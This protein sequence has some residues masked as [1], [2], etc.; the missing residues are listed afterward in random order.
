M[1][2]CVDLP[3][4]ASQGTEYGL[5]HQQWYTPLFALPLNSFKRCERLSRT[6][7]LLQKHALML[8]GCPV[9]DVFR[10]EQVQPPQIQLLSTCSVL[11]RNTS[12]A[13]YHTQDKREERLEDMAQHQ[14]SVAS[15]IGYNCSRRWQSIKRHRLCSAAEHH[16][17]QMARA[18]SRFS[19]ACDVSKVSQ[20][21]ACNGR[22]Y[23]LACRM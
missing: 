10:F 9:G 16:A 18:S 6:F 19:R 11:H 22:L 20:L 13:H 17:A 7:E 14:N 12:H 4:D 8:F 5:Q 21:H 15:L 1:Q 23:G 2:C 3:L